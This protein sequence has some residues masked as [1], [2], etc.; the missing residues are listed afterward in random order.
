VNGTPNKL[1]K[2]RK[3]NSDNSAAKIR[4]FY[5]RRMSKQ[6]KVQTS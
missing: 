1:L 5:N 2:E 3:P 4:S 6:H